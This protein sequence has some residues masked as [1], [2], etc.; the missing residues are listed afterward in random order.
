VEPLLQSLR[1]QVHS[2]AL[3]PGGN[4]LPPCKATGMGRH[5]AAAYREVVAKLE[6]QVEALTDPSRGAPIAA[7]V[8]QL[9]ITLSPKPQ[10]QAP[11]P[12]TLHQIP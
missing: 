6:D 7:K 11:E 9:T 3:L 5:F 2:V 4:S 8:G 1:F 12:D 10:T